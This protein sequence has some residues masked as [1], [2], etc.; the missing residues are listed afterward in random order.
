MSLTPAKGTVAYLMVSA[1]IQETPMTIP[2]PCN[3]TTGC[4]KN[5]FEEGLHLGLAR[6]ALALL[7]GILGV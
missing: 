2:E 4:S 7:A 6:L 5:Q 1:G 3:G